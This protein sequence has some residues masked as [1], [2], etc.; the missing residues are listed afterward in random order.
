MDRGHGSRRRGAGGRPSIADL[1]RSG[2]RRK[3]S[4]GWAPSSQAAAHGR[5]G[6]ASLI[7]W[8]LALPERGGELGLVAEPAFHCPSRVAIA[9]DLT[10]RRFEGL[11]NEVFVWERG[12]T[13]PGH[14]SVHRHSVKIEFS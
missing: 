6:L 12:G 2:S 10:G 3:K 11:E 14:G 8:M 9:A 1:S 7:D 13:A 5:H 4:N